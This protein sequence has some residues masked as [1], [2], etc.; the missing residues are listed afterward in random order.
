MFI[1]NLIEYHQAGSR[2][3]GQPLLFNR[4][5]EE[6]KFVLDPEKQSELMADGTLFSRD[7]LTREK[8]IGQGNFGLVYQ[9]YLKLP[10]KQDE[11]IKVAIKTLKTESK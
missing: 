8:V 10:S 3:S 11:K 9:G 5:S 1:L 6:I 4:Q 7:Y 2:I